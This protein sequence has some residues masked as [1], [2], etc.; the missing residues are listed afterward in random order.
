[1]NISSFLN[2]QNQYYQINCEEINSADLIYKMLLRRDN[3]HCYPET[4]NC[5]FTIIDKELAIY[6]EYDFLQDQ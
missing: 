1:M 3:L 2:F 6:F 4:I 5:S